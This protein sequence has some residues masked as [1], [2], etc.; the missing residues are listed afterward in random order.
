M[1]EKKKIFV[2][3]PLMDELENLGSFVECL[4][5]QHY[6][7]FE[8]FACVNQPE[9][10]W[11]DDR[12][13]DLCRR[14]LKTIEQLKK[15]TDFPVEMID[16]SSPGRGW[17]DKNHG[18]GWARKTVMDKISLVADENDI[19][20]SLDGDTVFGPDYFVSLVES[21]SKYP[22]IKAIS[23][24]YFHQLTGNREADRAI[25]R[26]EIYMRYYSINMLRIGN[27]YAFTALGSAMAV[28][29]SAYRAVGGMTPHKS[30]EDFYFLQKLRKFG[31]LLI[32]HPQR[33]YPAARFS[34]RVFFGTGPAMIKGALGDWSS[35]PVY[36][37]RFFD[38]VAETFATFP[39]LFDKDFETPMSQFFRE[40]F[41]TVS[42]WNSL[43]QNFKTTGNFVR[44]CTHKIDGLRILQYIKWR[45]AQQEQADEENLFSWFRHFYPD[46]LESSGI[47]PE[48][49]TFEKAE[50]ETLEEMRNL[51]V[52]KE[53]SWQRQIKIL[54]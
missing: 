25:L 15:I 14:N 19:I 53:K 12:K 16:K 26:Y 49:F 45:H 29:V 40:K 11:A 4:T 18:V 22:E 6:K 43:R 17:D 50:I 35:Y 38:E 54:R 13:I 47:T 31:P 39:T 33:V 5:K 36:D 3:V 41:K 28:R 1:R 34:D 2:A 8:V 23:V 46:G 10:W 20:V 30:G 37:F 44:A 9:K 32:D 27:P 21:F 7:H 51:L 42:P 52:T 48:S 24:P